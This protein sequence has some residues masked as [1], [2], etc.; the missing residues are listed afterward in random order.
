MNNEIEA[1]FSREEFVKLLDENNQLKNQLLVLEAKCSSLEE[2]LNHKN[3]LFMDAPAGICLLEGP[4]HVYKFVN[5]IYYKL[6]GGREVIGKSIREALPELEG[7]G[8]YELLDNVYKTGKPFIGNE[9]QIQLEIEG[10]LT[11]IYFNFIYQPSYD[12]KKNI[13]GVSVFCFDVTDQAISRQKTEHLSEQ[14]K[15]ANDILKENEKRLDLKVKERTA[16]LERERKT[17]YDLF[18]NAP[19][20]ICVFRG[21]EHIYEFVNPNYKSLYSDRQLLGLP[22]R[23]TAP[24]L[25]GQ[26]FFELLDNV[27]NK[28]EP[29]IGN[30]SKVTLKNN[31]GNYSEYYFNFIYQPIIDNNN[32]VTGI[33]VFAFNVTEQ[34]IARN[35]LENLNKELQVSENKY[36]SLAESLETTV[37]NRTNDLLIANKEIEY[38]RNKLENLFMNAPASICSLSG[39]EH[40]F[41]FTN[42][43]YKT[44]FGNRNVIG[45]TVR[46]AMHELDGQ[47]FFELLDKVYN[48]G[49]PFIGN[50][51]PIQLNPNNTGSPVLKYL[52]FI[53]QPVYDLDN[54]IE[55]I[56]V[57]T[58]DITEQV[59]A[60]QRA[61]KLTEQIEKEKKAL[62]ESEETF[63]VL[64]ETIPNLVWTAN[65]D[66]YVDYY[67]QKFLDFV[68]LSIEEIRGW[69]WKSFIHPEDLES[70]VV[71]WTHAI[72]T[73]ELYQTEYRFKKAEDGKYYWFIGRAL[74]LYDENKNIV[75]WFGACTEIEEQKQVEQE[76]ENTNKELERFNYIASHDLQSPLRTISSYSKLLQRRYENKLDQNANDFLEIIIN[77]S[78]NMKNL[79]DDLL[80]F[81]R[82]GKQGIT[83]REVRLNDVIKDILKTN[84][85]S[86]D[87]NNAL[88]THDDLPVIKAEYTHIFQI[89]QNLISNAIK[90]RSSNISPVITLSVKQNNNK[91]VFSVSDNGIGIEEKY[92]NHIFE[93]FKRLHN[94]DEYSGSGIGLATVKKIIDMYDEKIWVESEY[95]KGTTFFFTFPI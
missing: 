54:K 8:I 49:E 81:S 56:S 73:G 3:N 44:L 63:R 91:W 67:N 20:T 1:A 71:S 24:E 16:E 22:I 83:Y 75:K 69:G 50:E 7:Q 37:E 11:D 27:Y 84:K 92:F 43:T 72:Q 18:Y 58:F 6:I 89:Y 46:E 51:V 76:L 26:G 21:P 94:K 55:G 25:E 77:A 15:I 4:E 40:T 87:E 34:V 14:L 62:K 85:T 86:I 88:I 90:Y 38:Q 53:Y 65:P 45:K 61:E 57:F 33:T 64:A 74:P 70:T 17:L 28:S 19:A 82:V 13:N 39:A 42:N 95:G 93:L 30:E 59:L 12:S 66:G 2:S 60:R 78:I 23:A 35:R 36:R 47:G 41:I 79:I 5:P 29:F 48:T 10:Y 31:D 68:G 9:I 80:S 52:N 32:Q